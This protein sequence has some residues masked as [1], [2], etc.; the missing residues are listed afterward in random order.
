K[1][2][3]GEIVMTALDE[4]VLERIASIT[5]GSYHHATRGELE[6]D[7]IHEEIAGIEEREVASRKFTQ[8]EPRFQVPLAIALL[9]LLVDL[10]LPER[11]RR[12]HDWE[13]R[14]A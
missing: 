12:S 10:V 9:L 6:L 11:V 4:E 8:F 13:G 14:F 5:G 1:D 3:S 7:R 2:R